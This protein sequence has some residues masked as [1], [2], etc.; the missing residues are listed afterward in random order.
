MGEQDYNLISVRS[1]KTKIKFFTYY[2][3]ILFTFIYYSDIEEI[4]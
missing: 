1:L 3:L 4:T 2:R